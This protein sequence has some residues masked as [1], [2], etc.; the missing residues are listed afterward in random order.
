[1]IH[2][3]EQLEPDQLYDE[4]ADDADEAWVQ[5]HYRRGKGQGKGGKGKG[6][7]TDAVLNCPCCFTTLCMDCQQHERYKN[8]F[9]AMFTVNCTVKT[10]VRVAQQKT[11]GGEGKKE[12]EEKLYPVVCAVCATEVG[13]QDAEEVVHFFNVL[14]GS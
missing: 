6:P 5:R 12:E 10:P 13:V 7:E 1:M 3:T 4:T 8:Q 2:S 14:A 11:E 9:R